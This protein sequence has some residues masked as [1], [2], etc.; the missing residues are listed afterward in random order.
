MLLCY[1]KDVQERTERAANVREQEIECI[2]RNWMKRS[3]AALLLFSVC[4]GIPLYVRL[5]RAMP[6][7]INA[8]PSVRFTFI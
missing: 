1:E 3:G 7:T 4:H 5:I 2:Q 8:A 6:P